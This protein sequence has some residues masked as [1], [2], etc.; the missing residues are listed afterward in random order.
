LQFSTKQIFA[1]FRDGLLTPE[2]FKCR[3]MCNAFDIE[4]KVLDDM[5]EVIDPDFFDKNLEKYRPDIERIYGKNFTKKSLN[6]ELKPHEINSKC[7]KSVSLTK[8]EK[9]LEPDHYF[10]SLPRAKAFS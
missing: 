3:V 9:P 8:S 6:E 7:L 5:K 1:K 10:R 4:Y 2:Q